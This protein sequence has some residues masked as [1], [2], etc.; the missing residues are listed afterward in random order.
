[1]TYR[2]IRIGPGDDRVEGAYRL[3]DREFGSRELDSEG[4]MADRLA[5]SAAGRPVSILL[6]RYAVESGPVDG[7]GPV[8]VAAGDYIPLPSGGAIGA[9]GHLVTDPAGR[10]HGH[11][12]ALAGA[13][14]RSLLDE[15]AAQGRGLDLLLLESRPSAC[16]FWA[17]LAYRWVDGSRYH[18]PALRADPQTGR[19]A[20]DPVAELLMVKAPGFVPS[21][22]VSTDLLVEAVSSTYRHWY[23]P[24]VAD[25]TPPAWARVTASLWGPL[26]SDFLASLPE[27]STCRLVDPSAVPTLA[28]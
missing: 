1:M 4:A 16:A 13:F 3:L 17:Q 14:E 12:R 11:G 18:Q 20:H 27:S 5:D 22:S 8:A 23:Q 21:D 7:A 25:L 10:G 28:A 9:L 24:D 2:N 19:S 26:F 15:A 6:A